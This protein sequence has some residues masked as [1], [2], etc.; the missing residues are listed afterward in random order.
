MTVWWFQ[1]AEEAL[2]KKEK[3]VDENI[4]VQLQLQEDTAATSKDV[5]ERTVALSAAVQ[6][7]CRIHACHSCH[8]VVM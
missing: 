5:K 6:V 4:R 1:E 3:E 7:G 8:T 2:A